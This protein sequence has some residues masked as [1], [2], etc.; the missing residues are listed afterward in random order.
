MP[1]M[2]PTLATPVARHAQPSEF[3][4]TCLL[5]PP[6]WGLS[7]FVAVNPFLGH[8]SD[9][10][11]RAA[12]IVHDGLGAKLLP[13][14]E[15]YRRRFKN[16][17]F[18]AN[19]VA[20]ACSRLGMPAEDLLAVLHGRTGA[21][22]RSR[23][24]N[25]T[26]SEWI[27]WRN[28]TQ[29]TRLACNA[30]ARWCELECRTSGEL[31]QSMRPGAFARWHRF[32]SIDLSLDA[33]GLRGCRACIASMPSEPE[34]ALGLV[35]AELGIDVT[36]LEPYLLRL[37]SGIYGWASQARRIAWEHDRKDP[38]AVLDLLA[39]RACLDL[40][41]AR[42]CDATECGD[43]RRTTDAMPAEDERSRLVLQE[44]LEDSYALR[45]ISSMHPAQAPAV[46]RPSLQVVCCIDVRSEPIRRHLELLDPGVQ[47]KG[48]AGFFGIAMD[49]AGPG[50]SSPR[51]PVLLKP[52]H[53]LHAQ[54]DRDPVTSGLA[55]RLFSAPGASFTAVE[56]AGLAFAAGIATREAAIRGQARHE[57][58]AAFSLFRGADGSGFDMPA[59]VD[60][61]ESILHGMG[62]ERG[63][64]QVVVLCGHSSRSSNNPHASSLDCGACGGHGGGPNARVACALLNDQR[65]RT[66]L[67]ER[68]WTIPN[69]TLFV[70]AVHDTSEDS[71]RLLDPDLVPDSHASRVAEAARLLDRA[72]SAA[73]NERAPTLGVHGRAGQADA[74]PSL[75]RRASDWAEVRPEWGLAG[76]AAFI[77]ARRCR[78]QGLDLSSRAFLH[79]YDEQLDHD[80]SLL[81]L[82]LSAPM[83]V[84][85]WINLQYLGST[86]DPEVLG[87]GDKT[88]HNRV[89]DI[90]VVLG[91]EGDLRTGLPLQ[92]VLDVDGTLRHEPLRLQVVV[93]ASTDRIDAVLRTKPEVCELV[94]NGWVRMFALSP[95]GGRTMR[96]VPGEGWEPT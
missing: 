85:S 65:V 46:A 53:R 63:L 22:M 35:V 9:P 37:L 75:R 62:M 1:D 44:A 36:E 32:A 69:D 7:S 51:C 70:A 57:E 39:A 71:I 27:D 34:A 31:R 40:S 2:S 68:G 38:G 74:L 72:S 10:I 48:F 18:T 88:L 64:A 92:S 19:H 94:E 13:G 5:I 56:L 47:T 11:D 96:F 21:L 82:I 3:V 89:G 16:G 41:I 76:N 23:L 28:G 26:V 25:W 49:W 45:L 80:G 84:A 58:S 14:V 81:A 12:R 66:G 59:R 42:T 4:R 83:V 15:Y 6:T 78:T 52:V 29:W 77:A 67:S 90:G 86:V 61:A 87:S 24:P 79:D 17:A 60:L 33:E 50:T 54:P 43:A 93:E 55:D 91:S 30:L 20:A 95:D 73:R 8:A